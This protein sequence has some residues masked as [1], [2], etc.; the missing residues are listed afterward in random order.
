ADVGT[1]SGAIAIALAKLS[2]GRVERVH[3]TEISP[4]AA[5]VARRNAERLG[6][7][8]RVTVR[9][10]DLL[11]PLG[12]VAGAIDILASNPP[13]IAESERGGLAPEVL[14]EPAQALFS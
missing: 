8:D 2:K 12:D 14:A 1:G 6:A 11:E 10:G 9:E 7:A 13:Y 5:A 4:A 3:A